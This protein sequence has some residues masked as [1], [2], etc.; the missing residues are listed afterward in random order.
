MGIISFVFVS[1]N[2]KDQLEYHWTLSGMNQ[3]QT[4]HKTWQQQKEQWILIWAG[5]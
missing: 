1:H 3:L 5:N 2:K 4:P